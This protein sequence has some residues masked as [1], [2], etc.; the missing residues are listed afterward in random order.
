MVYAFEDLLPIHGVIV[1][2]VL[3]LVRIPEEIL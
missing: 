2:E 3:N 1:Q